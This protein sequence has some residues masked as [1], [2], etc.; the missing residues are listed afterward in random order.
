MLFLCCAQCCRIGMTMHWSW[1]WAMNKQMYN[2]N[3]GMRIHGEKHV[4]C[5]LFPSL[6]HIPFQFLPK[7]FIFGPLMYEYYWL[8]IPRY[9]RSASRFHIAVLKVWIKKIWRCTCM[10]YL[11]QK[12]GE[13]SCENGEVLPS[14]LQTN[15]SIVH[16]LWWGNCKIKIL[17]VDLMIAI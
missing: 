16:L 12:T 11:F 8:N 5:I 15:P 14:P 3:I 10:H 13:I 1:P 4:D 7:S 9:V 17:I 6:F 2:I